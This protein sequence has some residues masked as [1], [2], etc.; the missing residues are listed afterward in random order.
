LAF[1]FAI[2]L[3]L[4]A[5]FLFPARRVVRWISDW[6]LVFLVRGKRGHADLVS[7]S[8]LKALVR[9]GEEEGVLRPEERRMIQRLI[10]LGDRIVREIMTPRPD[11]IA[12]DLASGR[13]ELVRLIRQYHFSY[14]PVYQGSLDHLVGG[15]STRQ[16]MLEPGKKLEEIVLTPYY[17]P[18][19][20]AVDELFEEF[21]RRHI[22]FAVCVDEHG[23]TAGLVTLED[24]LE[25]VF[26]E[27]YDEY[28][29]EGELIKKVGEG[30]FLVH[31]KVGLH[32]LNEAIGTSLTSETSETLSGWLLQILGRIPNSNELVRWRGL[33]FHIKEVFRQRIL[34]VE[35]RKKK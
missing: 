17:V 9:I 31:G 15:I 24:I 3:D 2:P 33:D 4:F 32:Q 6:F 21:Q 12:F 28:S 18:E 19:T 16:F 27:F 26:G 20:K 34:T 1:L 22:Q 23:G 7:E 30:R 13:D 14:I 11:L 10:G 5:R 8:E 29:K 25:E 35:V